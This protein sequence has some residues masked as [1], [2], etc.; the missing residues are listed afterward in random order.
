M[1]DVIPS[2]TESIDSTEQ[3]YAHMESDRN[4]A[5]AAYF[6]A[7]PL[8]NEGPPV[9]TFRAGFERAYQLLWNDLQSSRRE[10]D[11]ACQEYRELNHKYVQDMRAAH[12]TKPERPSGLVGHPAVADP[13]VTHDGF[14]S[15]CVTCS[16]EHVLYAVECAG[17]IEEVGCEICDLQITGKRAPSSPEKSGAD[18]VYVGMDLAK[19]GSDSTVYFCPSC[20]TQ[21]A[22]E[23]DACWECNPVAAP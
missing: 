3:Y 2:K 10:T 11:R 5:E 19:P 21:L 20:K 22:W 15:D 4:T 23:G 7:R 1:S 18:P 6:T 9:E 12:E 8:L 17:W 14:L 16:H 13:A